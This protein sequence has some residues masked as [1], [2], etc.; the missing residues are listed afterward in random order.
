MKSKNAWWEDTFKEVYFSAFDSLYP[1]PRTK[2]EVDFIV[3]NL[4]LKKNSEILDIPCGQGRHTI[5]LSRRGFKVIGVDFSSCLLKIAQERAKKENVS[6]DFIEGDMRKTNLKKKFDA[7]IVL[8]NSFGYFNDA[9]NEKTIENFSKLLKKGGCLLLDLSNAVGMLQYVNKKVNSKKDRLKIPNGYITTK[10]ILFD[11]L[12]LTEE[13]QW[14]V[15]QN[16]KKTVLQGK[17]RIYTF[18]EINTLLEQYGLQTIKTFGSFDGKSYGTETPR[19][20]ILA[21]K[22]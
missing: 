3:D 13:L 12:K 5:E 6:T 21:K 4:S 10:E 9:D 22:E 11:P 16:N 15:V 20:I 2:E 14:I 19:L 7:I 8:G 17:L 18:P 1:L